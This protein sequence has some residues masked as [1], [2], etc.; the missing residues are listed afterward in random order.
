MLLK[1]SPFLLATAWALT[2]PAGAQT[3]EPYT[4][5][6]TQRLTHGITYRGEVSG[7]FADNQSPLW[8]TANRYGLS[9]VDAPN[10]YV[11]AG[12]FR[13][14]DLDSTSHWRMGFGVDVAGA[15]H[16]TSKAVV[17]QLYADIDYRL[18]RLTVGAKEQPMELKNQELSSGSQT[19]GINA[20]PVPQVRIGLPHYWNISGRGHWAA[21]KGFIA[22]GMLTDGRF[23][24]SYVTPGS[25]YARKAL[26]HAKAG[27]LKLGNEER[28]PLTFEGGLEMATIFGGTA[29]NAEN[30]QGIS[31]EPIHMGHGF[32]DFVDATLGIGGDSTDEAGYANATGNSLGSWLMRLNWQGKGWSASVYY[33]HYFED[34]SQ[35][36]WQY[37]WLDGLVGIELKLPH[38]PVVSGLV[39]EFLKTTYQSGPL[40]HDTTTALPDQVSGVDNYYNHNIYPGWQHWGQAMGNPLYV[41]PLYANNGSLTFTGNRFKAHHVGISGQPTDALRYRLLYTHER[42]LGTYAKPF[43]EARTTHS[44]LAEVSYAPTRLG[45]LHTAGWCLTASLAFDHG[46][47]LGNNTGMQIG[48]SK[49]GWLTK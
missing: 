13:Q 21:I 37:G 20:R 11:R 38:N 36:F 23:Q 17:Q 32:K 33:D 46:D 47:L 39:Y 49:T 24:E 3:S 28:F 41:S 5:N 2:T 15:L 8:L 34:H 1:L 45:R 26:Y 25:N 16:F 7:T 48:I 14:A 6:A 12:L 4:G 22:Y 19:L 42:C 43:D 27:Y 29:Y 35:M 44:F 40:Y 10:G 9:S 31:S 30:W 18:V